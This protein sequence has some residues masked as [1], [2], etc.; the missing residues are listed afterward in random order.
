[1][2]EPTRKSHRLHAGHQVHRWTLLEPAEPSR[3]R[4][5]KLRDRWF[6]RCACGTER[7]V[8]AQSLR[9]ALKTDFGGSRSCGCLAIERTIRHGHSRRQQLTSEYMAWLAAKKRCIN[10][11]NASFHRYGGRGIRMCERWRTSFQAFLDDMGRKP[12]PTF[13]LD[14]IDPNGNYEP[15]N[16]RWAPVNV[17]C[18]NR[19]GVRWYEFEGQLALLAD[20]AAFFGITRDAARQL[21]RQG[22]LPARPL[23]NPPPVPDRLDPL[24][25]D[26]NLV[27]PQLLSAD[28][29]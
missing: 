2:S 21:E 7:I 13:S 25:V 19:T 17:Q 6:C 26:L 18:R 10:P 15:S 20:I 29:A 8:L 11:K 3:S 16:C 28:E 9:L 4:T 23:A 1:M 22:L 12:D 27:A 5:G 14:R 24:V